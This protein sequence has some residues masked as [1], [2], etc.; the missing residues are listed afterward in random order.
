MGGEFKI[1]EAEQK[2]QFWDIL[3][4]LNTE[5]GRNSSKKSQNWKKPVQLKFQNICN[6]LIFR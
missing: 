3:S 6:Q 1:F 2:S 5:N 4:Y